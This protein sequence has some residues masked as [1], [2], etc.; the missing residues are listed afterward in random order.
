[1]ADVVWAPIVRRLVDCGF[2]TTLARKFPQVDA[3][4]RAMRRRDSW[5]EVVERPLRWRSAIACAR[6]R[7]CNVLGVG[8]VAL[9]KSDK[10]QS[11]VVAVFALYMAIVAFVVWM[12]VASAELIATVLVSLVTGLCVIVRIVHCLGV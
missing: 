9:S 3:W 8:I 7:L 2:G 5:R 12:Q 10:P 6:S 11:S 1:M 4:Y